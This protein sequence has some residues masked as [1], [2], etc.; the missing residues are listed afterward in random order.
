MSE[1]LFYR[2]V[3]R[4]EY[5]PEVPWGLLHQS[6]DRRHILFRWGWDVMS[7]R[8]RRS[9]SRFNALQP[10]DLYITCRQRHQVV[11]S[12]CLRGGRDDFGVIVSIVGARPIYD[13]KTGFW[14]CNFNAATSFSSISPETSF[15][16]SRIIPFRA[17]LIS[18]NVRRS[19]LD[20][21]RRRGLVGKILQRARL[22]PRFMSQWFNIHRPA[23]VCSPQYDFRRGW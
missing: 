4:F 10:D 20:S 23:Y 11:C 9:S 7:L 15:C 8:P 19:P 21:D 3:L 22:L 1:V 13:V 16:E 18:L 12:C 14:M 6:D 17:L 2:T 5:C